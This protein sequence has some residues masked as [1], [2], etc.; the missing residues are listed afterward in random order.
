MRDTDFDAKNCEMITRMAATPELLDVSR[1]W[2]RTTYAH[3]YSYH[4][5]WMGMPIIQ[6]PQDMVALQELIWKLRPDVVV[7]TGIARG[8]SLVFYASMLQLVGGGKVIGVDIDIRPHNREAIEAHPMAPHIALIEGSSIDRATVDEVEKRVVD[9]QRVLVVLD[10][11]HTHDHVMAEL[12]MYSPMVTPDS[13]LVVFDTI[14]D[15][16]PPEASSHRDWAPGNSPGS[17][18]EAFL[19]ASNEFEVDAAIT[20]KLLITAA[21]GGY[22][23]RRLG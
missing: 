3:E 7:E 15:E 12:E 20:D 5:E 13:Y 1:Q 8:G 18:V 19:Q 11:H 9:A 2:I 21:R 16:L 4:F 22:L 10:S 6:Y 23:R 17:A 14:V